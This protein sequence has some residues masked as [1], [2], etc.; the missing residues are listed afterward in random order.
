MNPVTIRRIIREARI[1]A[2]NSGVSIAEILFV[3]HN[4]LLTFGEKLLWLHLAVKTAHLHAFCCRLNES[5][6]LPLVGNKPDAFSQAVENLQKHRFL[7]TY[8]ENELGTLYTLSLPEE[9]LHVLLDASIS[10]T[11]TL[12]AEAM[13]SSFQSMMNLYQCRG[14][15]NK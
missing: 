11:F 8:E 14:K 3:L 5:D 12:K 7:H 4:N 1:N 15:K 6:I 9:G 10:C 13:Q 2:P